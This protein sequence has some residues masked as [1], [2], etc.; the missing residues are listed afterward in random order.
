M[1]IYVGDIHN[2]MV[3]LYDIG[4][5]GILVDSATNRVMISDT[6]LRSF[7]LPQVWKI[8]PRLHNICGFELCII[9]KDMQIGWNIFRTSIVT[10]SHK[11][12]LVDIH[13][14]V[15]IVLQVIHITM[16]KCFHMVN[17][18]MLIS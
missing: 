3:K 15:H 8:T 6:T 18:Y 5:L 13:S 4:D 14:T 12:Q 1:D 16:I 2:D 9:P 10:Y 17:V 7:I 11:N